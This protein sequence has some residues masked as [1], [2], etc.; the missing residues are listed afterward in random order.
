[1]QAILE[2]QAQVRFKLAR[3]EAKEEEAA[4]T[5]I[6]AA[7]RGHAA[8]KSLADGA[9]GAIDDAKVD[10]EGEGEG[11][12]EAVP[13]HHPATAEEAAAATTIQA[14]FRGHQT[15]KDLAAKKAKRGVDDDVTASVG[16]E[17]EG[18]DDRLD[19][20]VAE[21]ESNQ[22]KARCSFFGEK[23]PLPR[24]IGIHDVAGVEA[25]PYV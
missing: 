2:M 8:R 6:Q 1:V 21:L 25:R 20:S 10:A 11:E 18:E 19:A 5:T 24:G 9:G 13:A 3:R 12:S 23:M 16:G 15:R 4:A 14:S 17:V 22:E 7:Y